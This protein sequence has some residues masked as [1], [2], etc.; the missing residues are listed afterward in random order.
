M[1]GVI[2][3]CCVREQES[4]SLAKKKKQQKVQLEKVKEKFRAKLFV[5]STSINIKLSSSSCYNACCCCC[6]CTVCITLV[7]AALVIFFSTMMDCVR[8]VRQMSCSYC[9]Y[10]RHSDDVSGFLLFFDF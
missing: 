1:V 10:T 6:C 8:A 2:P 5:H 3:T 4:T 9:I 7:V